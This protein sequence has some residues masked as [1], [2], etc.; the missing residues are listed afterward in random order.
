[1]YPQQDGS[2]QPSACQRSR[3]DRLRH[4]S[5]AEQPSPVAMLSNGQNNY[6]FSSSRPQRLIPAYGCKQQ[7][8][9]GKLPFSYLFNHHQNH[10]NGQVPAC[11]QAA[12]VPFVSCKDL[13]LAL[14]HIIR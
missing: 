6:R 1:M 3:N 13:F 7:R 9:N 12:F 2:G 11:V 4:E 8:G 14:R 10:T 5:I